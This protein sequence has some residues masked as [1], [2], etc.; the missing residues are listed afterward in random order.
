MFDHLSNTA[1]FN[2]FQTLDARVKELEVSRK[3]LSDAIKDRLEVGEY[4]GNETSH[5]V[6]TPTKTSHY[7]LGDIFA[8]AELYRIDLATLVTPNNAAIAKLPEEAY[9][10]IGDLPTFGTRLN[11]KR[12]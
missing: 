5:A 12:H 6:L 10:A 11:V 4:V 1:L 9:K 7:N 8:V 3:A 2:E